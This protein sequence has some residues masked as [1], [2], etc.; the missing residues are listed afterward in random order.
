[1]SYFYGTPIL[2]GV[3]V[4][5]TARGHPHE[6]SQSAVISRCLQKTSLENCSLQL[7]SAESS[8]AAS[9]SHENGIKN[10][11]KQ[12]KIVKPE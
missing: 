2:K 6:K 10:V 12:Q 9:A 11:Q 1:M 4:A 5:N 8:A 7:T 3:A